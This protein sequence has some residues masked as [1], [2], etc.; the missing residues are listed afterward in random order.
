VYYGGFR[1]YV[2]VAQRRQRA[3]REVAKLQKR[4]RTVSPVVI[5]GRTIARTFWGRAWCDNLERY[6]DY[7]YRLPRGRSYV[8]NGSVVDLQ[9]AAGGVEALVSGSD[10]YRVSVRVSPVARR[11]W[12]AI[13]TDCTGGIDSLVAL[14]E[15]RLSEAVMARLCQDKTGLFPAPSEI[16]LSCSCPDW[17]GLCKHVAAALYGVGARLDD[18]PQLLFALRGVDEKDLIAHAA[19]AGPRG[20]TAPA[21]GRVLATD[22]LSALFGVELAGPADE[23]ARRK[24]KAAPPARQRAAKAATPAKKRLAAKAATPAKKRPAPK[25]AAP[26]TSAAKRRSRRG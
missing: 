4:G 20:R 11:R 10:L 6:S 16:E 23:P 21:K 14:L 25:A 19:V 5:E 18:Q 8:R 1:P 22:D 2:P 24:K 15:G 9:I 13:C 17:A 26:P 3:A 7:A 12:A